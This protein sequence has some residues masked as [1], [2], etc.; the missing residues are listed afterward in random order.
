MYV[1]LWDEDVL[2]IHIEAT[3]KTIIKPVVF[4]YVC[5]LYAGEMKNRL[6]EMIEPTTPTFTL[7]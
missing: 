6:V 7:N 2:G 3:I 4:M 1:N 5:G